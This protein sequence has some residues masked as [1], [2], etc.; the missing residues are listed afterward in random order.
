MLNLT[1]LALLAF[2]AQGTAANGMR[3]EVLAG[4][5]AGKQPW[6]AACQIC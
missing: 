4:I 6:S 1:Y 3:V 5:V 2:V